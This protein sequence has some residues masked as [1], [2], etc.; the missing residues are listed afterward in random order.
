LYLEIEKQNK[1]IELL[2]KEKSLNDLALKNEQLKNEQVTNE[3]ILLQQQIDAEFREREILNLQAE[4]SRQEADLK[5]Q[6]IFQI[7][8]EQQIYALEQ[9]KKLSDLQLQKGE[10]Q[11]IVYLLSTIIIFILLISAVIGY[12]NIRRSRS[13]ISAKNRFIE[14]QNEKLKD[15]NEE[16]N[17]LI[18]IVAHDLKNPL[19]SALTLSDMIHTKSIRGPNEEQHSIS[20]IRRSL[21]RMQE[22][23]NKI[24]DVKAIDSKQLNL[25]YEAVNVRLIINYLIEL[26]AGKAKKK[27]ISILNESEESY[28]YVDRDYFIQILENLISNALKFSSMNTIVRISSHESNDSCQISVADEGP[29]FNKRE[30]KELFH[31]N[32]KLS[33]KPTNG[34]S[35]NG[36]GLS[37]VKKYVEA[38]NGKVWCETTPGQGSTFYIEFEKV[39]AMA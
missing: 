33:P 16:K 23:I 34:E 31:E 10:V 32:K 5:N 12:F 19:T 18:R 15:L 30:L 11:R 8:N 28:I 38:M 2:I 37:I 25:E 35:S 20:L 3:N 17:R 7:T 9:E 6:R 22:M 36:L 1:D 4:S 13:K 29:G 24:L 39:M 26:F 27:N 21:R 14:K